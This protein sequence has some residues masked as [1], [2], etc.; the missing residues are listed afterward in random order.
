MKLA[1]LQGAPV[2]GSTIG[3]PA[4]FLAS[5]LKNHEASV[6]LVSQLVFGRAF[7]ELHGLGQFAGDAA[8]RASWL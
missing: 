5:A 4:Q 2:S 3:A 7:S 6:Q 1:G 8:V